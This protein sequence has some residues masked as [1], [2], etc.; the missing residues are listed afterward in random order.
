MSGS[1]FLVTDFGSRDSYAGQMRAVLARRAP[2]STVVDITHE[3]EPFAIDEGAWTIEVTLP[4]L[5]TGSVLLGVVDPGVGG[6]RQPLA[7][8]DTRG[9]F[10]VGPDNG[11]LAAGLPERLRLEGT[12]RPP[13]GAVVSTIEP[14]R[15]GVN[16]GRLSS[17]FHGR[18]LFAPAAALLARGVGVPALGPPAELVNSLPPFEATLKPDRLVGRVVHVDTFGNVITTIRA[19]QAGSTGISHVLINGHRIGEAAGTFEAI[20]PGTTAWHV[21]SSGFV[22]LAAGRANAAAVLHAARGDTVEM[23]LR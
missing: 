2:D 23:M 18:D 10:L 17:T 12:V 9:H 16:A 21:D 5:P 3:I 19:E 7:I 22:A 6:E 14:G 4:L 1:I 15:L 11:L 8:R 13:E 20:Q